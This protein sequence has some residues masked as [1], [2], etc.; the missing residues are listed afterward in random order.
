MMKAEATDTK[1]TM[2]ALMKDVRAGLSVLKGRDGIPLTDAQIE[3]R[4]RNIVA[5]LIG[6][7]QITV[8]PS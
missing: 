3:E 2:A 5:G 1:A 6:N 7:Y 4:T 8:I